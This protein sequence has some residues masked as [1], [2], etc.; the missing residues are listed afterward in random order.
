VRGAERAL[1]TTLAQQASAGGAS[2][3]GTYN[4]TAVEAAIR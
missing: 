3:V 2:Y 1:N 4:S